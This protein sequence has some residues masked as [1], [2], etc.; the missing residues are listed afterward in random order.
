MNKRE[1]N[2]LE[3]VFESEIT[4]AL[5]RSGLH[6]YQTRSKIAK[7]LERDGLLCERRTLLPGRFPV[8]VVGYELTHAGRI[9]YCL[10]CEPEQP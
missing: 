7:K 1:L 9:A 8:E 10:T 6:L 4:A 3:R 2:L 5:T